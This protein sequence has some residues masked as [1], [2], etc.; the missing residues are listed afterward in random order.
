MADT[1]L[2]RVSG[3]EP[4]APLSGVVRVKPA[5]EGTQH[6]LGLYLS[7]KAAQPFW[8]VNLESARFKLR[9]KS[10]ILCETGEDSFEL[11]IEQERMKMLWQELL[12]CG[13]NCFTPD[14]ATN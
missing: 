14:L 1:V 4:H 8:K 6:W 2:L 9:S 7:P 5:E 3:N 10:V 13:G 12:D 11:K